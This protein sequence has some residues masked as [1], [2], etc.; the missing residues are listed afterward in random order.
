MRRQFENRDE[1]DS[2][3]QFTETSRATPRP[4]VSGDRLT[5]SPTDRQGGRLLTKRDSKDSSA[6]RL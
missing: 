5:V 1:I 6:S 3:P 4:T 2:P